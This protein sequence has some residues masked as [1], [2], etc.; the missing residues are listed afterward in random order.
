MREYGAALAAA[1]DTGDPLADLLTATLGRAEL[2][3]GRVADAERRL[4]P[5]V[6]AAE[7]HSGEQTEAA[8][9]ARNDLLQ[10]ALAAGRHAEAAEGYRKLIEDH[11]EAGG[12]PG[13]FP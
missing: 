6:K 7:Q 3:A 1:L 10:V 5:L 12:G 9:T 8:F 4:R 2:A 11:E 13:H